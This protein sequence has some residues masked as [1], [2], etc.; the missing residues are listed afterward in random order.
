MF[1]W[2]YGFSEFVSTHHISALPLTPGFYLLPA[3]RAACS[4]HILL[5]LF[6]LLEFQHTLLHCAPP[7]ALSTSWYPKTCRTSDN[8][9]KRGFLSVI[10]K[11]ILRASQLGGDLPCQKKA[12]VSR[13]ERADGGR[14][15]GM[16][17]W[18]RVEA[19]GSV[20]VAW[21]LNWDTCQESGG[22]SWALKGRSEERQQWKTRWEDSERGL[23]QLRGCTGVFLGGFLSKFPPL[24]FTLLT[25]IHLPRFSF[26]S[27]LM[28]SL[29]LTCSLC[30]YYCFQQYL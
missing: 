30:F 12:L 18:G 10:K 26:F 4:P 11:D 9:V 16:G 5:G 15:V 8:W 21:E 24:S 2:N 7:P 27:S 23:E 1:I 29:F 20:G 28:Y 17:G 13:K 6:L 14:G 3:P 22:I 25:P 19:W